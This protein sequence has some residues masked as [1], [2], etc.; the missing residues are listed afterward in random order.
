MTVSRTFWEKGVSNANSTAVLGGP[1]KV[2][3]PHKRLPLSHI[4][5]STFSLQSTW[6]DISSSRPSPLWSRSLSHALRQDSS[7]LFDEAAMQSGPSVSTYT[8][9]KE[10]RNVPLL[11]RLEVST[12]PPGHFLRIAINNLKPIGHDGGQ[13]VVRSRRRMLRGGNHNVLAHKQSQITYTYFVVLLCL[14]HRLERSD[15]EAHWA[16]GSVTQSVMFS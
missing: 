16:L 14:V 2:R 3:L 8:V 15:E 11:L 9:S 7:G 13:S 4:N 5:R 12:S 6:G 1:I 10:S